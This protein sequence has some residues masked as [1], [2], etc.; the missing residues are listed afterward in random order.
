MRACN[1]K[2]FKNIFSP[3]LAI[4]L[5]IFEAFYGL[6]AGYVSCPSF[7]SFPQHLTRFRWRSSSS[8]LFVPSFANI[9][10]YHEHSLSL[11]SLWSCNQ[12]VLAQKLYILL[13]S[14]KYHWFYNNRLFRWDIEQNEEIF[15]KFTVSSS[16]PYRFVPMTVLYCLFYFPLIF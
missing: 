13:N 7:H 3:P 2:Y 9:F 15:L 6:S 10:M 12:L 11:T 5:T 4:H 1:I 14:F 16:D 8:T